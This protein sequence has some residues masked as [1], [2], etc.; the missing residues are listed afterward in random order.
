MLFLIYDTHTTNKQ[1]QINVH[2]ISSNQW[3]RV[4]GK[5][6]RQHFVHDHTH[7]PPVALG[8]VVPF[9]SLRLEY[10][11]RYVIRST[12]CSFTPHFT[13]LRVTKNKIHSSTSIIYPWS[14]STS[15][16]LPLPLFFLL[17][18]LSNPFSFLPFPS[19]SHLLPLS[20]LSLP[21]LSTFMHVPKS[22]S[23]RCPLPSSSM[24]S[25]FTSLWTYPIPWTAS[26]A[27]TSSAM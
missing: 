5:I 9:A 17:I 14:P 12:H 1:I 24:F 3:L 18:P 21:T 20:S 7:R 22:A 13:I 6:P 8:A 15:S 19:Y 16:L 25:G 27:R 11:G 23:F 10:F 26:S 2:T 4:E